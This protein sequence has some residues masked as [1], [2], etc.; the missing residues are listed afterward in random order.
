MARVMLGNSADAFGGCHEESFVKGYQKGFDAG[1]AFGF[2]Q[3]IAEGKK[4]GRREAEEE[5]KERAKKA[6]AETSKSGSLHPIGIRLPAASAWDTRIPFL[7][8]LSQSAC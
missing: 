5:L 2:E 7:T 3:A 1:W 6:K 8:L 4:E